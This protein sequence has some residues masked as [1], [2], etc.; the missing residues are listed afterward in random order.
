MPLRLFPS[1]IHLPSPIPGMLLLHTCPPGLSSFL[2][3]SLPLSFLV[4]FPGV[5]R[6]SLCFACILLPVSYFLHTLSVP[7][8]LLSSL[9][10]LSFLFLSP[11]CLWLPFVSCTRYYKYD[12]PCRPYHPC[13]HMIR[14][15]PAESVCRHY[16]QW[17]RAYYCC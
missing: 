3:F 2:R 15:L 17:Y 6:L 4:F 16:H 10:S 13:Y 5:P 1:G 11:L 9:F 12:S 7:L 8:L 14:Y